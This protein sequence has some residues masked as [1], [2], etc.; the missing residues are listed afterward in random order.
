MNRM[1]SLKFIWKINIEN[2]N[3]IGHRIY[4]I[5]ILNIYLMN[6]RAKTKF[7][8]VDGRKT[9]YKVNCLMLK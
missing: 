7:I 3:I 1:L 8:V 2:T 5:F 6:I 9:T 4:Y